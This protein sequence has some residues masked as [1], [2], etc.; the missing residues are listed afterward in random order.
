MI[1]SFNVND[2]ISIKVHFEKVYEE[3][4]FLVISILNLIVVY[5]VKEIFNVID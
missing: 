3:K 5:E 2:V 1:E 4:I